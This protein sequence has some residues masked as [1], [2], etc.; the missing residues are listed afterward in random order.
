MLAHHYLDAPPKI[1]EILWYLAP[2][3]DEWV[4]LLSSRFLILPSWHFPVYD[5]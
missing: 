4:A 1:G 5:F 2:W 3:R